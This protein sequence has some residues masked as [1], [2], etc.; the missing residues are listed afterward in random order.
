MTFELWHIHLC[1]ALLAFLLLPLRGRS[2]IVQA[3]A[4]IGTLLL[5]LLPVGDL[6]LAVYLR[7]LTHDV[8]VTTLMALLWVTL[9]R[10]NLVASLPRVQRWTL[11]ILFGVLGLFLYPAALGVGPLDP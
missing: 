10:M 4:L 2:P 3:V 11:I 1:F 7:T 6:P 5:G 9:V 8:S